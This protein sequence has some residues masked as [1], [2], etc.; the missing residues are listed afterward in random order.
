MSTPSTPPP[1]SRGGVR[2]TRSTATRPSPPLDSPESMDSVIS[3]E[4]SI[5]LGSGGGRRSRGG[6]RRRRGGRRGTDVIIE[7][8][9]GGL[10]QRDVKRVNNGMKRL[11]MVVVMLSSLFMPMTTT[12]PINDYM[13]DPTTF[14]G[15]NINMKDPTTFTGTNT[16]NIIM[17]NIE[18]KTK[19]DDPQPK[20]DEEEQE[21]CTYMASIQPDMSH[22]DLVAPSKKT[23]E[24]HGMFLNKAPQHSHQIESLLNYNANGGD[25]NDG[26]LTILDE[27]RMFTHLRDDVQPY[28]HMNLF[29]VCRYRRHAGVYLK[30]DDLLDDNVGRKVGRM[31]EMCLGAMSRDGYDHTKIDV[32]FD[33]DK[34]SSECVDNIKGH[35]DELKKQVPSL[36]YKSVTTAEY[37]KYRDNNGGIA[38]ELGLFFY[39]LGRGGDN[40]MGVQRAVILSLVES[41]IQTIWEQNDGSPNDNGPIIDSSKSVHEW[42]HHSAT[43][44]IINERRNNAINFWNNK[45]SIALSEKGLLDHPLTA[46][47]VTMKPASVSWKPPR[48]DM[49]EVS[50]TN[51][52]QEVE[53][54]VTGSNE[55]DDV[56]FDL[57]ER[58]GID[59][60]GVDSISSTDIKGL[61]NFVITKLDESSDPSKQAVIAATAVIYDRL[62]NTH[63][64]YTQGLWKDPIKISDDADWRYNTDKMKCS[65]RRGGRENIESQL[66]EAKVT[67]GSRKDGEFSL[68]V[69]PIDKCFECFR[70]MDKCEIDDTIEKMM[71]RQKYRY[72]GTYNQVDHY[73][74]RNSDC[75][76]TL[77]L[78]HSPLSKAL[79]YHPVWKPGFTKKQKNEYLDTADTGDYMQGLIQMLRNP[80]VPFL[81][82]Q[83]AC[84]SM[85]VANTFLRYLNERWHLTPFIATLFAKA[86]LLLP[87]ESIN[88]LDSKYG[89]NAGP[90]SKLQASK[91]TKDHNVG[92]KLAN[93]LTRRITAKSVDQFNHHNVRKFG[94]F[95]VEF[96]VDNYG[97]KNRSKENVRKLINNIKEL[98]QHTINIINEAFG[99]YYAKQD[100]EQYKK[101]YNAFN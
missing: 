25:D 14:T 24:E 23:L 68:V 36:D 28:L 92:W 62:L 98:K 50:L 91:E 29:N 64:S 40:K 70:S 21:K 42:L 95:A 82:D 63:G 12:P 18:V 76:T 13:K 41:M 75:Q 7:G 88:G 99:V 17:M 6:L 87:N 52:L 89:L 22:L 39:L 48:P 78:V 79:K 15:T 72:L 57:G 10:H 53:A 100:K 86:F 46:M 59:M 77:A 51:V 47:K 19:E 34:C 96:V 45:M 61:T 101:N 54:I 30:Q 8:E 60:G 81:S 49:V 32:L 94:K 33:L 71:H 66:S 58:F 55:E 93:E 83:K 73:Y 56:V 80:H 26:L 9:R 11:M 85:V 38:P 2:V 31:A 35:I 97:R 90:V 43:T 1:A 16:N 74:H 67:V 20:T 69:V 27:E 5:I 3:D 37:V 84:E 4:D 65:E 44:D